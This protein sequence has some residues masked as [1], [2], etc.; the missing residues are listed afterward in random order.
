[1]E[2]IWLFMCLFAVLG[3]QGIVV[4]CRAAI[5]FRTVDSRLRCHQEQQSGGGGGRVPKEVSFIY[6]LTWRTM[7]AASFS[8]RYISSLL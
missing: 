2:K 4:K 1:M 8:L 3:S 7:P 6:V 5:F